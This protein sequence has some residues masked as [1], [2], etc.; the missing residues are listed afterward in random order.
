MRLAIVFVTIPCDTETILTL[1]EAWLTTQATLSLSGFTETGPS[2]TGIWASKLGVAGVVTSNTDKDELAVFTANRRVPSGESR[3]G[4]VCASSKFAKTGGG[5]CAV[6]VT[7][8]NRITKAA[9][10]ATRI[11][12]SLV[13]LFPPSA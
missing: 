12:V 2:P 13:I 8:A 6:V 7:R 10:K 4:L 5:A 9:R 3:M 1:L 11:E